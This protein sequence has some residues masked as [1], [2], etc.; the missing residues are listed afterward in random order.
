MLQ[1]VICVKMAELCAMEWKL[2]L[3]LDPQIGLDAQSRG[4]LRHPVTLSISSFKE[5]R[6]AEGPQV[7]RTHMEA[8]C[9]DA[10]QPS[11]PDGVA[12]LQD[13]SAC[14]ALLGPALDDLRLWECEGQLLTSDTMRTLWTCPCVRSF[15]MHE[16]ALDLDA[17]DLGG[18]QNLWCGYVHDYLWPNTEIA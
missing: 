8:G 14:L 18:L 6:G 1:E 16:C 2:K 11:H 15:Q 5:F 10:A 9:P 13:F 7:R 17:E 3:H 4:L 12:G